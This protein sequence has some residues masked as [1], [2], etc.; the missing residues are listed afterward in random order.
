MG[1]EVYR[2][3]YK[4]R[5]WNIP[6]ERYY[7]AEHIRE[8]VKD[9]LHCLDAGRVDRNRL[10]IQK[11]H[12]FNRYSNKWEN[13]LPSAVLVMIE[14]KVVPEGIVYKINSDNTINLKKEK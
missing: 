7:S 1:V 13:C 9:F 2:F 14:D 5:A 12:M 6:S 10:T 11:V 3:K 4:Y 8:A